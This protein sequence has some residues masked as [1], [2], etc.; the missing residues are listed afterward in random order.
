MRAAGRPPGSARRPERAVHVLR[1]LWARD[2]HGRFGTRGRYGAASVRGTAW[3]TEDR[4]DG[5]LTRVSR[6]TVV[7]HDFARHRNVVVSA[8]HGYLARAPRRR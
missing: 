4:C 7:V 1:R 3:L 5:T 2:N 8:G 6:G